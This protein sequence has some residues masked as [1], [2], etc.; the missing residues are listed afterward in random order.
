MHFLAL[1]KSKK[2]FFILAIGLLTALLVGLLAIYAKAYTISL[3]P[4]FLLAAIISIIL[5][6]REPLV[7]LFITIVYCFLMAIPSREVGGLPYGVG[8]EVFL[9]LTWLSVWYNAH[10]YDFKIL[11]NDLIILTVFWFIISIFE[12]ANFYGA[13]PRGWLQ[14][15]RSTALYPLFITPLGMLL[16]DNKKK[17]NLF[18]FTI[19][20]LSLLASL[21]GIQQLKFG[22]TP[23][24]Q[25]FIDEGG[26]VTHIVN[27][28]LRIFSFY[29]DASQFGPSQAH[30]LIIAL[31]LAIGLRGWFKRIILAIVVLLSFY[32][33]LISGT[34][35]AF[36]ALI[37]GIFI[38]LLLSKNL[39]VITIGGAFAGILLFILKFTYIGNSNYNIYRLR[40]ALD[41][42]DASLNLRLIN[43][44][45]LRDFMSSRPF[46][47]GLGSIG[48]WATE[49]NP[50][51][52]LTTIPP[53][54]YW[55][56]VWVMYGIVGL[57]IFIC[58][59]FFWI[60]KSSGMIWKLSDKNL[61]LKLNALLAGT[62]GIFVCSYGNEVMNAMPSTIVIYLSL[63]I[64]Y[65][66]CYKV[67]CDKK[68]N[69]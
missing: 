46:G 33:L 45:K 67:S 10:R 48:H 35:G 30:I 22:L 52:Y 53:D 31:V 12:I 64:I 3:L 60:G 57:I 38:A 41:P 51:K 8:I 20:F 23:G 68:E 61:R 2:E 7:G 55:V 24:E 14:E 19:L 44:Q 25:K 18:L 47:T 29:S 28:Q 40:T 4:V 9:T 36:F 65:T 63:G 50:G 26:Y 56:K 6:F 37:I 39:K 58:S 43:Q 13:S 59:W 15:I 34:R 5:I 54:S 1:I 42:Q 17:V 21:H 11:K 49:Y 32:G 62:A 16:I 66:M 69:L 27:G